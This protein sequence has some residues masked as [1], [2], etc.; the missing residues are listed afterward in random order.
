MMA[1]G[2]SQES[3][4]LREAG[5]VIFN[6]VLQDGNENTAHPTANNIA[7]DYSAYGASIYTGGDEDWIQKNVNYLHL[8]ELRLSWNLPDKWLARTPL[9]QANI[10]V[11]GNDLA[12]WTNYS[13]IDAVGN[14]MSAAAGGTGGE[15]MDIWALPV[16]RGYSFGISVTFNK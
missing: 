7:V 2:L 5:P 9:S 4:T 8:A 1:N 11:A 3:V 12:T 16:P 13:G 15:G 10:F 14:T 6:G